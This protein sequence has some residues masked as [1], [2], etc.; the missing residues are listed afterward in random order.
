MRI[1]F[2]ILNTFNF[3]YNKNIFQTELEQILYEVE[4]QSLLRMSVI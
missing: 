1:Y 3:F 2:K 4:G